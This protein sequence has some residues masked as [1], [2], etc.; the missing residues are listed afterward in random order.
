M[1]KG[2]SPL[3]ATVM[4]IALTLSVVGLIGSWFVSMS[5]S[6]M[7]EIEEGGEKQIE[8]TNA[9]LD[10][11]SVICSNNTEELKIGVNNIGQIN[12]YDFST[13][14]EVNNT[15]YQNSTGG[16]NSTN[17]LGPGEQSILIYHCDNSLYCAGGATVGKVRISP[18]N[19]P[20]VYVEKNIG[21][22]CD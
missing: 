18:G 19:C 7:E 16:P 10:I 8:C 1:K 20:Q 14:V 15:F 13:F 12:L 17:V 22:T 21:V 5:R 6:Q 4:L 2:L 11:V 3:L 9:L